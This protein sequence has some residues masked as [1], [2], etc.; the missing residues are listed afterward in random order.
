MKNPLFN[1]LFQG[2][3]GS[4]ISAKYSLQNVTQLVKPKL[5]L[6]D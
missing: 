2:N 3:I 1:P 4:N 5:K 6:Y